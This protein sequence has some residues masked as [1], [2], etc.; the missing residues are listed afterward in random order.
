MLRKGQIESFRKMGLNRSAAKVAAE[1][2]IHKWRE[3]GAHRL[4][5]DPI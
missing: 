5:S 4:E 2:F 3:F 1:S